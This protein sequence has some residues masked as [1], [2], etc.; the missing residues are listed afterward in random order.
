MKLS[1]GF[2]PAPATVL[3]QAPAPFQ[4]FQ[5]KSFFANRKL[6]IQNLSYTISYVVLIFSLIIPKRCFGF[7]KQISDWRWRVNCT[8]QVVP[9]ALKDEEYYEL[10]S[11]ANFLTNSLWK[12]VPQMIEFSNRYL[13]ENNKSD[14]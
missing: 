13:G 4:A 9:S 7:L 1:T 3:A 5:A 6:K 14:D 11:L 10:A 12:A 8:C 2:E